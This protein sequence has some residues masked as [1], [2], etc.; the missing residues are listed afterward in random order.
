[1]P[2]TYGVRT[3]EIEKPLSQIGPLP[4]NVTGYRLRTQTR[5]DTH[6]IGICSDCRDDLD[7]PDLDKRHRR[8]D[9][10][11]TSNYADLPCAVC[12]TNISSRGDYAMHP[13]SRPDPN[14]DALAVLINESNALN[15]FATVALAPGVE[16]EEIAHVTD[17]DG[18]A[19]AKSVRHPDDAPKTLQIMVEAPSQDPDRDQM[20][21]RA[22]RLADILE[23]NGLDTA[24]LPADPDT[25]ADYPDWH[26]LGADP[27]A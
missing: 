19:V 14:I 12:A 21:T 17:A 6:S 15:A 5:T 3:R 25:D 9:E 22:D 4:M 2:L 10:W 24:I 18:N 13:E 8:L 26:V 27:N 20:R 1:M 11:T 16:P 7:V 23:T